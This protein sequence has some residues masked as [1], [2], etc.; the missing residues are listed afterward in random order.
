MGA[1]VSRPRRGR[2]G[3]GGPAPM[4][5]HAGVLRPLRGRRRK[6]DVARYSSD[7]FDV[8]AYRKLSELARKYRTHFTNCQ[9]SE[10]Y[11]CNV[12]VANDSHEYPHRPRL[13]TDIRPNPHPVPCQVVRRN[14]FRPPTTGVKRPKVFCD[15]TN[16]SDAKWVLS[17]LPGEPAR[18]PHRPAHVQRQRRD[19]QRA[20]DQRVEQH[21]ERD[22]EGELEQ[23]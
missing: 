18:P 14:N 2:R 1:G 20:D 23:E 6:T 9:H 3:D 7:A 17:G 21:A 19:E 10:K 16:Y 15:L 13:A 4:P 11:L 8:P 22:E 5:Q 12:T